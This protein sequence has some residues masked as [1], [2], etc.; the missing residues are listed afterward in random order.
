[1]NIAAGDLGPAAA[2]KFD[3]EVW[4]PSEGTYREATSCSNYRDFSARRLRTRVRGEHGTELVHTLNGTA[5]AVSR[6]LVYLFE[7]CQQSDGSFAVPDVLRPLH[8]F[9]DRPRPL[10]APPLP[11]PPARTPSPLPVPAHPALRA[12]Y[13]TDPSRFAQEKASGL[14][15][16]SGGTRRRRR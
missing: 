1:M 15:D 6:T 4:L 3:I 9:H 13:A 8:R 16:R 12:E 2:K 11:P 14:G 5:C 10:T 7:H